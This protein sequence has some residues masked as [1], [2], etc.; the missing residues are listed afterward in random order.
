M[1]VREIYKVLSQ[2]IT[3][4]D[5]FRE[6]PYGHYNIVNWEKEVKKVLFCVTATAEVIALFKK[7]KYDL[8]IQHHPFV[9]DDVPL[10]IFHT[11]LDCCEDGLNDMWRNY[12]EVKNSF[13]FDK[14]MGWTGD[15]TPISFDDLKAKCRAFIGDR[16]ILGYTFTTGEL[17]KSV[18]ICTGLGGIDWRAA[19]ASGAECYITG[20]LLYP[21]PGKFKHIIEIG[22]T[23]TEFI[24]VDLIRRL[25]PGVKVDGASL[26]IDIYGEET[27]MGEDSVFDEVYG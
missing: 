12:L 13:H 27:C 20:Q 8:L 16:E 25:L 11:A 7:K 22:H 26:D 5:S 19:E 14:N 4:E 17:V 3:K 6:E 23:Q 9:C 1:K 10:F 15:I 2:K 18:A 24:G 21:K